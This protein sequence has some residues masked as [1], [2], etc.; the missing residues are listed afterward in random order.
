MI[1][2]KSVW[3]LLANAYIL[4]WAKSEDG[5]VCEFSWRLRITD[6]LIPL[7]PTL[8]ST[9]EIPSETVAQCLTMVNQT[10]LLATWLAAAARREHNR[11]KEF[12]TW[13]RYG[14]FFCVF[15]VEPLLILWR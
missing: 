13:L 10:V 3:S 14:K 5:H 7:R 11:F 12:M 9:F 8:N 15:V 4:C 6:F 2:L 1:I